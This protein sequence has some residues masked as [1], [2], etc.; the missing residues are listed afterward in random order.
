VKK[1]VVRRE[2][3]F[4]SSQFHLNRPVR[5][6][7]GHECLEVRDPVEIARLSVEVTRLGGW[8]RVTLDSAGTTFPSEPLVQLLPF[9]ALV[10]W[11]HEAHS[12]GIETYIS[13]RM[14]AGHIRLAVHAGVD[15]VGFGFAIHGG[16]G[17]T[18]AGR[19]DPGAV[20]DLIEERN[21]EEAS[22]PGRAAR[23]LATL[24]DEYATPEHQMAADRAGLRHELFQAIAYQD[25]KALDPLL[26]R[27]RRLGLVGG[28]C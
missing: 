28:Q 22:V 11:V 4:L 27:G 13:G 10:G 2:G 12:A 26:E 17:T 18:P 23:L 19:I 15:G 25:V 6:D 8:D 3:Q 24:D 5:D 20:K 21:K 1:S 7:R 14:D 16:R 9:E